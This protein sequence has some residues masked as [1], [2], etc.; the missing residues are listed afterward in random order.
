MDANEI[1][2]LQ[3]DRLRYLENAYH[4]SKGDP[5]AYIPWEETGQ[6]LG[7]DKDRTISIMYWLKNE[8]LINFQTTSSFCLTNYGIKITEDAI[9]HPDI[10][11]GPLIA[12][13]Q[14]SIGQMINSSI[15]QGTV[16]SIQNQT[17]QQNDLSAINDLIRKLENSLEKLSMTEI[18]KQ[19][20][21]ANIE[22]IK[23]QAKSSKP[24]K[25]IILDAFSSISGILQALPTAQLLGTEIISHITQVVNALGIH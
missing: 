6:E 18:Q 19:D 8:G 20:L 1:K 17:I 22:T 13:N 11:S 4:K 25:Q 24:T 7:F 15:Q 2:K 12:Y 14:I 5:Q 9:T 21:I 16:N 23:A 3:A 10:S